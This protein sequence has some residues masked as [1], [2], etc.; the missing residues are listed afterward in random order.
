[1]PPGGANAGRPSLHDV[2]VDQWLFPKKKTRYP[3]TSRP[4]QPVRENKSANSYDYQNLKKVSSSVFITNFPASSTSQDLWRLCNQ[5]AHVSDVFISSRLTK[6]GKRFGFVRFIGVKDIKALIGNLRTIWIGSFH[7]FADEVRDIQKDR[8]AQSKGKKTVIEN[9]HQKL[10]DSSIPVNPANVN[11]NSVAKSFAEILKPMLIPQSVNGSVQP[12]RKRVDIPLEDCID[13]K[14]SEFLMGKVLEPLC[15]PNLPLLFAKEGFQEVRFRY[16]GGR[17]IGLSFPNMDL[18]I[19]F[20]GCKELRKNFSKIQP[21]SNSFIPDERCVWVDV[22]GLPIVAS[23][24]MVLKKVG[25]LWGEFLFFGNDTVEPL[26]QGKVCILTKQMSQI[27]ESIEVVIG[28]VTFTVCVKEYDLWSPSLRFLEEASSCE[29]SDDEESVEEGE[30]KEENEFIKELN[31]EV[32]MKENK[33]TAGD[34]LKPTLH[35]SGDHFSP[36]HEM[37][38]H[39]GADSVNKP[40]SSSMSSDP[41]KPPGFEDFVGSKSSNGN[42]NESLLG[43]KSQSLF[44]KKEKSSGGS[45]LQEFS[46]FIHMDLHAIVVDSWSMPMVHSSKIVTFK[47]KLK[48]L[49]ERIRSW[50]KSKPNVNVEMEAIKSEIQTIDKTIDAGRG[51]EYLGSRRL[52]LVKKLDDL[53]KPII[54]DLAQKAKLRWGAVGDE[55]SKFYHGIIN[56]K[57]RLGAVR[58]IKINGEWIDTP[59]EIKNAFLNFFAIKFK[60]ESELPIVHRS[61][62][63]RRLCHLSSCRIEIPPTLEEIKAAVWDCGS[64]KAP[65]PDGFSFG[66]LKKF[67][68]VMNQDVFEFVSDFFA[69]S[70]IPLGCNSSFITLIPKTQSPCSFDDYRPI[71]LVGMQ[72]KILSKILA[73]RLA[74]VIEEVVSPEQFAFIRGRQILDGPLS[75]NEIIDW[76]SH[77]KRNLLIFKID[78]A[79]AYDSVSWDYLDVMLRFMGFGVKWRNWIRVCLS[80]TRSSV[81]VNGS[82]T[83]EFTLG[84]GLRQ[85]DPLA[86]FLFILIME[87]LHV[88]VE[89]ACDAGLFSGAR[90]KDLAISHFFYADDAVFIGQWSEENVTIM[91]EMLK[92]FHK[93]SG[94]DINLN[95]SFIYGVGVDFMEVSR[96]AKFGGCKPGRIPFTYLGIP[97]GAN[98]S[99]V[100]NWNTITEK[101]LKRLGRWKRNLLSIGGRSTLVSSVLGSLGS[102]YF[103]LFPLPKK[104]NNLLE[105]IRSN[106]FWGF[107]EGDKKTP[108]VSWKKTMASKEN[109]GIGIGSLLAMNRALIYKWRWR[110]VSNKEAFWISDERM[111]VVGGGAAGIYGA[112]RAKTLALNLNVVVVEKGKPLAKGLMFYCGLSELDTTQAKP[113]EKKKRKSEDVEKED[114]DIVSDGKKKQVISEEE[115]DKVWAHS[116]VKETCLLEPKADAFLSLCLLLGSLLQLPSIPMEVSETVE[117]E[118]GGLKKHALGLGVPSEIVGSHAL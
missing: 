30:L 71:S 66:F 96:I 20:E 13:V 6:S 54:Q 15:L 40:S 85:G 61:D 57:R 107:E 9:Q 104:V 58:G 10:D 5:W 109:G 97:V 111:V 102:Y 29:E 118:I 64:D 27:D 19:K 81:L 75:L 95:K 62:R 21:I 115:D 45:F 100:A 37:N 78:F 80:S 49:K 87:G 110:F 83:G 42:I 25:E 18:A 82:P 33:E 50:R 4:N 56:K 89:D 8:R 86:P 7:L 117:D 1:M 23:T 93:V 68:D 77:K 36:L 16:I 116:E 101:F 103:S 3:P 35:E 14:S 28:G 88:F 55:N 60:K 69:N 72:Y 32:Q 53:E 106:F 67:W 26:S 48:R 11:V 34:E 113:K 91:V 2:D 70:H 38:S 17:W 76:Y 52:Q 90:I 74:S 41:S 43:D 24:P 31:G 99:R 22:S 79:K 94:L 105:S 73:N 39:K 114:V 44:S 65:G 47:E 84:R 108:W 98:M 112:I 51:D 63:F 59:L 12:I 46:R 92:M